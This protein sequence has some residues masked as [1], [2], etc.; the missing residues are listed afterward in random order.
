METIIKNKKLAEIKEINIFNTSKLLN[1]RESITKTEDV[2]LIKTIDNYIGY[3]ILIYIAIGL[4]V[5]F[6]INNFAKFIF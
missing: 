2:E 4:C 3:S 5:W 1:M 6:L